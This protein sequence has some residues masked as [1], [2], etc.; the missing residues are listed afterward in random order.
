M[1]FAVDRAECQILKTQWIVDQSWI[2]VRIP[3]CA[4]LNVR[5]LGLKR[6]LDHRDLSS[7]L[8]GMAMSSSK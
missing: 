1:D 4:G 3:D 7:A 5:T 2:L 6:S 8:L